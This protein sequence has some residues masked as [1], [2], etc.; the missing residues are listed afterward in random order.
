MPRACDI[1]SRLYDRPPMSTPSVT[2]SAPHDSNPTPWMIARSTWPTVRSHAYDIAV[3]PWG[4]TEAHGLHLPYATDAYEVDAIAAEAA[5]RAWTGGTKVAVLPSIPFGVQT[6]QA[7]LPFC[8]NLM[9][10]TQLA[11]LNDIL[12][13]IVIGTPSVRRFVLFNGHGGNDFRPIL[14]ELQPRFPTLF[15]STVSWYTAHSGK[16]IVDVVGDHADER[17]TSLMLHIEPQ[18]VTPPD[19]WGSGESI[20]W[21]PAGL[22]DG[23]AWAPRHWS[24][25]TVD[26]GVGD[27]RAATAEKGRRYFDAICDRLAGYFGELARADLD[28]LYGR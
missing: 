5:R 20:P 6:G 14:R 13:S 9:P 10:S 21:A 18:L 15:L 1:A 12:Q 28:R 27:P 24:K 3:L 17:E 7:D 23:T 22:R 8:V 4:A 16:G 19:T 26:T 25:A 2:S 11:M